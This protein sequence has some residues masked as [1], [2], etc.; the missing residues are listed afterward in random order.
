MLIIYVD[1]LKFFLAVRK[2]NIPL[3]PLSRSND[4]SSKT[5]LRSVRE[6]DKER[7]L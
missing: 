6:G 3:H 7:V 4:I 5:R 2:K 1:F